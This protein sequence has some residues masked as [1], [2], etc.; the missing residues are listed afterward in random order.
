MKVVRSYLNWPN[1]VLIK[2]ST[3]SRHWPLSLESHVVHRKLLLIAIVRSDFPV[4]HYNNLSMIPATVLFAFSQTERQN[5]EIG[6]SAPRNHQNA[7]NQY[8]NQYHS[9][10]LPA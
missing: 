4:V 2:I 5:G 8:R 7:H 1:Y 9:I 6:T 3:D 10:L